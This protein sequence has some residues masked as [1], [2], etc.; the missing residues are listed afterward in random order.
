[1]AGKNFDTFFN[2]IDDLLFVPS[3]DGTILHVNYTASRRLGYSIDEM[4]GRNIAMVHSENDREEAMRIVADM[5]AGKTLSCP[6]P[7]I[8]KSGLA[9][10][11][12][13]RVVK[14]EWNG[15]PALFGV[16]KDIS[17]LKLS[18]QKFSGIFQ[19]TSVLMSISRISDGMFIDINEAFLSVFGFA[20]DEVI[21]KTSFELNIFND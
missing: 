15:K 6:L 11:V 13:T 12:E 3:S 8:A 10:P 4:I 18:E 19:Q 16:T 20:R 5:I 7:V 9:I 2:T 1:M 17:Q 21:G 14:G